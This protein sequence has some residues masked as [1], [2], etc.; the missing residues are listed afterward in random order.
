[1]LQRDSSR[2]K[3]IRG[4]QKNWL[5]GLL[6]LAFLGLLLGLDAKVIVP[7]KGLDVPRV[8]NDFS[9][10]WCGSRVVAEGGNP[11]PF[12]PGSL[13]MN[14]RVEAGGDPLT[15]ESWKSPHYFSLFVLPFVAFPLGVA[16]T[17][18]TA[19]LQILLGLGVIL[20][21]RATGQPVTPRNLL[22]G[23]GLALVWRYTFLVMLVGNASMFL[24]FA[25]AASYFCSRTNRPLWA[26]AAAA[27][28]LIKPQVIF[29]VLP[30]L[31]LAP[32]PPG[33]SWWGRQMRRRWLGFGLAVLIFAIYSFA[34]QPGWVGAWLNTVF[35]PQEGYYNKPDVD[36]SST[37]LRSLLALLLPA[38]NLVQPVLLALA[39]PLWV[40]LGLFWWRHRADSERFPFLLSLTLAVN[41]LTSPYIRDY[42]SGGLLLFGL[43]Y[44]FMALR[45]SESGRLKGQKFRF[46]FRVSSLV[47]LFAL[48]PYPIN[49]L[50]L[51]LHTS[52]FENLMPL[53]MILLTFVT[54]RITK[55]QSGPV[56]PASVSVFAPAPAELGQESLLR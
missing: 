52:A 27:L 29:L 17:L 3:R 11:Y 14:V 21:I 13:Y 35:D 23:L 36:L 26:G 33:Q 43:L 32:P 1:M 8:G 47:W 12:A 15:T 24:F 28:L 20:V 41:V 19:L 55:G 40:G 44:C 31:L 7:F 48:L 18:W 4:G 46:R 22:L 53:A 42:D 34:L 10:F 54:W 9:V 30:L 5:A 49:L 2:A 45:R 51:N 38:Q 6:L 56:A 25:I 50:V 39:L 37:S 16:A